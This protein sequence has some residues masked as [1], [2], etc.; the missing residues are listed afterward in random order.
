[1]DT[2]L[3]LLTL[4]AIFILLVLGLRY[5]TYKT[6]TERVCSRNPESE[7]CKKH[8]QS[9]LDKTENQYEHCDVVFGET[10]SGGVKTVVCYMDDKNKVV[11]KKDASKVMIRELD[12]KNK[13]VY[14]TWTPMEEVEAE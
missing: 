8:F 5:F 4:G 12:S 9:K 14:E 10:P 11:K 2:I 7:Y 13:P 1:M 6:M 3:P